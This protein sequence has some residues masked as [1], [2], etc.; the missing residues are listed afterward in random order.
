MNCSGGFSFDNYQKGTAFFFIEP[1]LQSLML[2]RTMSVTEQIDL[3]TTSSD[4]TQCGQFI[5]SLWNLSTTCRTNIPPST[6]ISFLDNLGPSKGIP[7]QG[8][9]WDNTTWINTTQTCQE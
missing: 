8:W 5:E 1:P 4:N 6:C 2:N 9:G 7:G 3:S